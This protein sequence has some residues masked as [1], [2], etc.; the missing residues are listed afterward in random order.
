M[1][2]LMLEKG[3]G[4][5]IVA[6]PDD[7]TIWMAGTILKFRNVRWTIFCLTRSY[8][9]DRAPRFK[10]ACRALGARGIILDMEDEGKLSIKQSIPEIKRRIIK[11]F[12]GERFDYIFTH[13]Y[14][15]EYGHPRHK[16]VCQAVRHLI[17]KKIL[18]ANHFFAFAYRNGRPI[19]QSDYVLKLP[20]PMFLIA[21]KIDSKDPPQKKAVLYLI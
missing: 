4:L 15:G 5:V 16:A 6:H 21:R 11:Q 17:A 7:E 19:K 14:N 12:K 1:R 18:K 20:Q 13:G 10:K 8:D 2:N 3:T 9:K